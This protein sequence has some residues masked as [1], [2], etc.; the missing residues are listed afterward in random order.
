MKRVWM[1]CGVVLLAGGALVGAGRAA[2]DSEE[3][4]L[5]KA[6]RDFSEATVSRRLEGFRSFL[7]ENAS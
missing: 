7:A 5:L 4:A 2:G 3:A 6:D 1:L